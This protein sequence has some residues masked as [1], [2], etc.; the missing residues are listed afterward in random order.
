MLELQTYYYYRVHVHTTYI[1]RLVCIEVCLL[2]ALSL[3][4]SRFYF[5]TLQRDRSIALLFFFFADRSGCIC[6]I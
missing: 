6:G 2:C 1:F 4:G 3:Y 5:S